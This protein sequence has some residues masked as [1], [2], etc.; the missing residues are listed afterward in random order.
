MCLCVLGVLGVADVF[1][2]D[3]RMMGVVKIPVKIGMSQGLHISHTKS[4]ITMVH[5]LPANMSLSLAY[6]HTCSAPHPGYATTRSTSGMHRSPATYHTPRV[7]HT[8][9][10]AASSGNWYWF[11]EGTDETPP[12]TTTT[13]TNH[14][15][16]HYSTDPDTPPPRHVD[17]AIVGGGPGGLAT[18]N[19]LLRVDPSLHVEVRSQDD[20]Q[21]HNPSTFF[22]IN[23]PTG[24]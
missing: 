2:V 15:T 18:A 10:C 16:C 20:H 3:R 8:T 9:S 11:D 19:A 4:L 7:P 24:V 5:L 12:T 14:C 21:V 13:R 6:R 23:T 22:P 17:V 1:V